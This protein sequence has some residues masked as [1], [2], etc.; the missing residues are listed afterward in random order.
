MEMHLVGWRCY[1]ASELRSR[2]RGECWVVGN[3]ASDSEVDEV[4]HLARRVDGPGNHMLA[5]AAHLLNEF[6]RCEW[7]AG[8]DVRHWQGAPQDCILR[9]V[10]DV[11]QWSAGLKLRDCLDHFGQE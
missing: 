5:C 10:E 8:D 9:R 2:T 11:T 1:V 7:L 4:P 3:E 6:V